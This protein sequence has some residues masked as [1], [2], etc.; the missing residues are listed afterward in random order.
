MKINNLAEGFNL[1]WYRFKIGMILEGWR[2]KYGDLHNIYFEKGWFDE[3]Q[4]DNAVR[5]SQRDY[6]AEIGRANL[7]FL[8]KVS[9]PIYL[10]NRVCSSDA[11]Q[12]VIDV[13]DKRLFPS[14]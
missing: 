14:V 12:A 6:E 11:L 3:S 4:F 10:K 2:A 5:L 1:W 9:T 13:E 8:M 7:K